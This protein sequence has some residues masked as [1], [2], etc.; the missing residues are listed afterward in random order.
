MAKILLQSI[1][2]RDLLSFGPDSQ[3]LE[4]GSLNLLIGPNGS[5][6]SNLI[7]VID[8]LRHASRD[9][10]EPIRKGG[11]IGEW[12]FKGACEPRASLKA[13]VMMEATS[14]LVHELSFRSS[15]QFFELRSERIG[16][17]GG[18]RKYYQMQGDQRIGIRVDSEEKREWTTWSRN[19]VD[20]GQSILSQRQAPELYPKLAFLADGYR[21]IRIYRDWSF[22]RKTVFRAPQ[23]ADARN[24][25]LEEDFSN[26]GLWLNK[27]RR[28]P[29]T[30]RK[31]VEALRDLYDG[32]EDFDVIVEG[33]TV[34]LFLIEGDRS[35]PATR[36]SDGTLRFLCLLAILLDPEPPPLICLEEPE[37]G[38]HPDLLPK[39][40]DL[41]VEASGR[42]QI[43]ATTHSDI[44]VDALTEHPESIV[45]CE[46]HRGCT[47]LRRLEASELSDWLRQYRLGDLWTRGQL[48]GNRW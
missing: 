10:A 8:L 34:Q 37:L 23:R 46:K 3:P 27:L 31:V 20:L 17:S 40:A 5:G 18:N 47:E 35:I 19:E 4:L 26:L 7:D 28:D 2:P 48:G 22:G 16:S 39:V 29:P 30:R 12:L 41:L 9:F 33:G 21:R 36:L 43:I 45:I 42:T 11:G 25:R 32:V 38:L 24:D 1:H 44:V 14:S 15:H 13:V 6:K